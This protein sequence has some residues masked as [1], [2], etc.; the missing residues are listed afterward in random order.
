MIA[1]VMIFADSVSLGIWKLN[2]LI[3]GHMHLYFTLLDFKR[4]LSPEL[5]WSM[6]SSVT[7]KKPVVR[8]LVQDLVYRSLSFPCET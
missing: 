2:L 7:S 1:L 6:W 8:K 3:K 5:T 4:V